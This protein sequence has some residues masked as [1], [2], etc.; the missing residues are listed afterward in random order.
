[1]WVSEAGTASEPLTLCAGTLYY[2]RDVLERE[3]N[4]VVYSQFLTDL[5]ELKA[6]YLFRMYYYVASFLIPVVVTNNF[7]K[8]AALCPHLGHNRSLFGLFLES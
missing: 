1:M 4:S 5:N 6:V 8:S 2:S 3:R 7:C